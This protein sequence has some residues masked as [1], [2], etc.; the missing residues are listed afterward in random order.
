VALFFA[1]LGTPLRAIWGKNTT[2]TTVLEQKNTQTPAHVRKM[3]YLCTPKGI[4]LLF[5][6]YKIIKT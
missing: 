4:L 2:K 5:N 6:N 1:L 3:Y